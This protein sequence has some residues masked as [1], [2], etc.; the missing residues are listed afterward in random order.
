VI[1]LALQDTLGNLLSGI[2]LQLESSVAVG[3]WIRVDERAIGQVKEIR[4]RSTV[5]QTKNGDTVI[6]PNGLFS[7]SVITSFNKDGLENRRWVY[8]PVHLRHPPN[9]VQ[10]VVTDAL[11]GTPNVSART[12][13]DCLLWAYKESYAE[14]AVRYRLVD[15]LP[16]DP[17][18]SEVRKRIWYALRRSQIEIPYPARNLFVTTL[19]AE[20]EHVKGEVELRCRLDSIARV[21]FLEPLDATDRNELAAGLRREVYGDGE[22]VLRAGEQGDSLYL[23]RRGAVSVRIGSNGLE[24]EVAVLGEGDFFGEMGLM[25]GEPRRATVVARGDL[26]CYV[27]DRPLFQKIL[28]RRE[29]LVSEISAL[30]SVRE[31]E[32]KGKLDGLNQEAMRHH[33]DHLALVERIKTFFG[34][35]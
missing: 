1:G 4:W 35:S 20:R 10:K 8:F 18:D 13:P 15:F 14:Y 26:D 17:T 33:D 9:Q 28:Q 6:I 24:E 5:I 19:D 34:L 23:V 31:R 16:D 25:T 2:A 7:K 30:L 29:A 27:I 22:V 32:L 3:D 12:P 11:R 21:H